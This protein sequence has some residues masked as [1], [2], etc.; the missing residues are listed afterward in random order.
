MKVGLLESVLRFGELDCLQV[1]GIAMA[2]CV[3]M[4]VGT[5]QLVI[6]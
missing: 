3:V 6:F 2:A 5:T 1:F 4:V